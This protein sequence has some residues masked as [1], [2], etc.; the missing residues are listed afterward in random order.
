MQKATFSCEDDGSIELECQ[1]NPSELKLSRS[2]DWKQG[3][4]FN[5]RYPDLQF[6][7]AKHDTLKFDLMFDESGEKTSTGM[8]DDI[9]LAAA[10]L[11]PMFSVAG[12]PVGPSNDNTVQEKLDMLYR[13]T[14]PTKWGDA[15]KM[16]P[17]P[18]LVTFTWAKFKFVGAITGCDITIKLFDEDGAPRRAQVGL[19]LLGRLDWDSKNAV[20][21]P[22][23]GKNLD[24]MKLK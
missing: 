22:E 20:P 18:P 23:L 16:T 9:K 12:F 13:M 7:G 21:K 14:T 6:K 1:F 15:E 2:V 3:G 19:T 11:N 8:G 4:Q 10:A 5:A 24:P 17:R